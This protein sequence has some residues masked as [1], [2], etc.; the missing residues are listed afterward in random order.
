M[1]L[2]SLTLAAGALLG[3]CLGPGSTTGHFQ[4]THSYVNISLGFPVFHSALLS[5]AVYRQPTS[6]TL[7]PGRHVSLQPHIPVHSAGLGLLPCY[8]SV[9]TKVQL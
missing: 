5:T 1:Y 9:T 2:S 6:L 3:A 8:H 7:V 4:E